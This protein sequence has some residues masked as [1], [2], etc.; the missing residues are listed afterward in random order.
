MEKPHLNWKSSSGT[1]VAKSGGNTYR[2]DYTPGFWRLSMGRNQP[3]ARLEPVW[4][5]QDREECRRLADFIASHL[6]AEKEWEARP[7]ARIERQ[8]HVPGIVAKGVKGSGITV[9]LFENDQKVGDLRAVLTPWKA[10]YIVGEMTINCAPRINRNDLRHVGLGRVMH[11]IAEELAGLPLIP[12]GRNLTPGSSSADNEKF[13]EKRARHRRVP[14]INDPEADKRLA[15]Y[16]E[17]QSYLN[18]EDRHHQCAAFA[19]AVAARTGWRIEA[20]YGDPAEQI[21]PFGIASGPHGREMLGAWCVMPDGGTFTSR[22]YET[23]SDL[24]SLW[25]N[26]EISVISASH[27]EK[28]ELSQLKTRTEEDAPKAAAWLAEKMKEA[29]EAAALILDRHHILTD[30]KALSDL[31]DKLTGK[32]AQHRLEPG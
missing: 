19:I 25:T 1:L 20:A 15:H 6:K 8:T 26:P 14:G 31:Q 27:L 17:V 28:E 10:D 32:R 4:I 18:L 2:I 5:S 7:V 21:G 16:K 22:G 11:D 9:E 13:W 24:A 29:E 23:R 3:R 30:G 12:H